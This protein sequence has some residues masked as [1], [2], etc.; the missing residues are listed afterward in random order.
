M[1]NRASKSS[2]KADVGCEVTA[3]ETSREAALWTVGPQRCDKKLSLLV[4]HTLAADMG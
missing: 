3:E 2:W 4:N 1:P